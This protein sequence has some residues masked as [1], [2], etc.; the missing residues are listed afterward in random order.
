MY[1]RKARPFIEVPKIQPFILHFK[2]VILYFFGCLY[3]TVLIKC[4]QC[5]RYAFKKFTNIK[6][7]NIKITNI[8]QLINRNPKARCRLCTVDQV[9]N[10]SRIHRRIL[11]DGFH[12][13]LFVRHLL[14]A[15][16]LS[17]QWSKLFP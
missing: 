8:S 7:T 1:C 10:Q 11:T 5:A 14:C 6:F 16:H 13:Y 15:R 17:R 2:R 4:L 3:L 12:E 9:T